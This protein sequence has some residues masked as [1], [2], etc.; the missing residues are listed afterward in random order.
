M[1]GTGKPQ[2]GKMMALIFCPL[3]SD[4]FSAVEKYYA[5][6]KHTQNIHNIY[7]FSEQASSSLKIYL[8]YITR[9]FVSPVPGRWRE[10]ERR[11]FVYFTRIL[12]CFWKNMTSKLLMTCAINYSC[13]ALFKRNFHR[14]YSRAIVS[15]NFIIPHK[16]CNNF[17]LEKLLKAASYPLE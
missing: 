14:V 10:R 17:R 13:T 15:I 2:T 11:V 16:A 7:I 5:H 1:T 4:N 6:T 8:L 3:F 12:K 9:L